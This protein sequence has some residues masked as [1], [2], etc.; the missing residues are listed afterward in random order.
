MS[1]HIRGAT[2]EFSSQINGKFNL[3]KDID[4]YGN[5]VLCDGKPV[6]LKADGSDSC[7]EYN[8]M[9]GSWQ[10]K[11]RHARGKCVAWA[12]ISSAGSI[13]SCNTGIWLVWN[14]QFNR[15]SQQPDIVIL[16]VSPSIE[17]V[18]CEMQ[19][20][21]QDGKK[22]RKDN[23][24]YVPEL[25][26]VFD[27]TELLHDRRP[28]YQRRRCAPSKDLCEADW[29]EYCA[30]KGQWQL[31]RASHRGTGLGFASVSFSG[32]LE[33]CDEPRWRVWTGSKYQE[34]HIVI[35]VVE[36]DRTGAPG[37][38]LDDPES[39]FFTSLR[40]LLP[41]G[42]LN[43]FGVGSAASTRDDDDDDAILDEPQAA[44]T[45][46]SES[47]FGLESLVLCNRR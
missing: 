9:A 19:E 16:P 11:P 46:H 45:E 18:Y 26:G 25:N 29:I 43:F 17:L 40:G 31:K 8:L 4:K 42:V 15:F 35:S 32:P 21:S 14:P 44:T 28:V 38:P 34:Q 41:L 23:A 2:G 6:Y 39:V 10:V 13:E 5:P 37:I 27:A 36:V 20:P 33:M 24:E 30:S 3:D 1:I 7:V 22:K 47:T 12:S